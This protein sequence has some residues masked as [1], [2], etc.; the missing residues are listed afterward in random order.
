MAGDTGPSVTTH[1]TPLTPDPQATYGVASHYAQAYMQ[2]NHPP[3]ASGSSYIPAYDTQ[4]SSSRIQLHSAPS[5]RWYQPGSIR[6]KKQGCSFT[7]SQKSV[8]T[9]MMD[10]HLIYPQGW[11]QKKRRDDW[12]ADP[13][14]K[15]KPI[16]IQGTTIKLDTPEAIEQWIAERKKRFPTASRVQEKS[17]KMAEAV[18]RGQLAFP[19]QRFPNKKRRIDNESKFPVN[20]RGHRGGF[21]RGRGRGAMHASRQQGLGGGERVVQPPASSSSLTVA[22]GPDSAIA[23]PGLEPV[24]A[25]GI[26]DAISN[27]SD[28]DSPPEVISSKTETIPP[29]V[30]E[31]PLERH[32]ESDRHSLQAV[33]KPFTKQPRRQPQNPFA[34]RPALLRNLLLPEIRNTVSNLSQAIR[35]LVDNNFLDN[36]ELKPGQ[37]ERKMIEVIHEDNVAMTDESA[38]E[39][40]I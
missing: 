14:L 34:S 18:A 13:T 11:E 5:S 27:D 17:Q 9:H 3:G 25:L 32:G 22:E 7:G 29:L 35:F 12:D 37:A 20:G 26:E 15:G 38:L 10:R 6:C 28:S 39:T 24:D 40:S 16:P 19:D 2:Y 33:R 36:V 31:P 21:Q 30:M 4:A 1:R 23:H 8:E